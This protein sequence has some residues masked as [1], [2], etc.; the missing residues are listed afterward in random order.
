[1]R[2]RIV[3]ADDHKVFRASIR[4]MLERDPGLQVVGEAGDGIEALELV[5]SAL[6]DVLIVDIRMPRLSG[7]EA[8][9]ELVKV[10]P[11]VRI[12]V[13]SLNAERMF[14]SEMLGAGASGYVTKGDARELPR[15]IRAVASGDPYLSPEV[16]GK[17]PD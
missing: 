4:G 12:I 5:R 6:P 2:I 3:L 11:S 7:V 9:R 8:I 17:A 1:M 10:H 14:A 13:F 15:A 16:A